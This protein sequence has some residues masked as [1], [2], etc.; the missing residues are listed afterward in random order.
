MNEM[1]TFSP[2][3]PFHWIAAACVIALIVVAGAGLLLKRVSRRGGVALLVSLLALIFWTLAIWNPVLTR[4]VTQSGRHLAVVW[5]V[6]DSTA[7]ADGGWEAVRRSSA[8]FLETSLGTMPDAVRQNGSASITTFRGSVVSQTVDLNDLPRTLATLDS[9]SFAGG[10]GSDIGAGLDRA[11]QQIATAGGSGEILLITDGHDT[12]GEA[13]AAA[14]RLAQRGIAVTVLPV[15]GREP[16]VAISALNLTTQTAARAE[17]FLRGSVRNHSTSTTQTSLRVVQYNADGLELNAQTDVPALT[18]DAYARLRLPVTF[19]GVGLQS[20]DVWL[21]AGSINHHRRLYTHVTR[22]LQLLAVGGDLRFLGIIPSDVATV[23]AI[24]PSELIPG[25]DFSQFDGLII[26]E[27]PAEAFDPV[28]LVE[29]AEAVERDGLGLLM[30]N[31]GHIGADEQDESMLR[32]YAETPIAPLL[33]VDTDP[34]PFEPEPPPRQVVFFIDTSGS[35]GGWPLDKAKEIGIYIIENLLRPEDTIDVVAFTTGSAVIVDQ[36]RMDEAGKAQAVSA[37][38][39][40][41]AGGGTDPREALALIRDRR[42]SNCGLVFL[43]DGYFSSGIAEARPDCRATAFGIGRVGIPAGDPLF[44]LADPF[45]VDEAFDP[46][47]IEIPYFE[48]EERDKFFELGG[49]TPLSMAFIDPTVTLPVPD[50]RLT[51]T[52]VS[53]LRDDAQLVAVRPKFLDPVLAY[54]DAGIGRTGV[55]TTAVPADW[56]NDENGREAIQEY[57]LEI[58]GYAERERYLFEINDDGAAISIQIMVRD[59][60]G[61]PPALDLLTAVIEIGEN[62][63]P[64]TVREIAGETA[65]YEASVTLPR[66]DSLQSALLVVQEFGPDAVSRA[67]RIP[68]ALPPTVANQQADTTEAGSYGTNTSLLQSITTQTGGAYAPAEGYAFFTRSLDPPVL[69]TY[70]QW[71][72]VIG[73]FLF[74]GA[75]AVQKV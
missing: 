29:V 12:F 33:P 21:D 24:S 17:T 58:V 4:D 46:A 22:P 38:N 51:G 59:P 61:T 72:V 49:Y 64:M 13:L 2:F 35:M 37:I 48:P 7:R 70:W 11:A 62:S 39:G 73:A 9:S 75:I 5:D 45:E 50:L 67:Q 36:V 15:D 19:E 30:V 10:S 28:V 42:M 60:D 66:S 69:Q 47:S 74:L 1:L 32:S 8:E 40:L 68:L 53:Y 55:F 71:L 31:G 41:Q 20:V 65:T 54:R 23:T 63:Y 44:E 52:A 14:E 18:P 57:M 56:L 34:R 25:T 43:S 16:E 3:A 26:S 27:A 6:S